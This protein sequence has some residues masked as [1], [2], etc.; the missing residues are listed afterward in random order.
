MEARYCYPSVAGPKSYQL[1]TNDGGVYRRNRRDIRV[2]PST[3]P[4]RVSPPHNPNIVLYPIRVYPLHSQ[5]VIPVVLMLHNHKMDLLMMDNMTLD[6]D[7][8]RSQPPD[9]SKDIGYEDYDEQYCYFYIHVYI[10]LEH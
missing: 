1:S 4:K 10:D 8:Y 9:I 3:T 2:T 5:V 7:V 6:M